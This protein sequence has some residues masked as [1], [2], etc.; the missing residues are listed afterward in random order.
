MPARRSAPILMA[1]ILVPLAS[2]AQPVGQSGMYSDVT[3]QGSILEPSPI[4]VADDAQLT[5]MI[6]APDGARVEVFARGLTNPRMLAVSDAGI[7][8]ATRRSVGDVVMLRDEDG[9]GQAEA[10]VTVAS[11][12]GMHGIAFDGDRV[13]LATVNDVYV[14]DVAADGT[15]GPLT[16]IITDL[17]DAGQHPNR[18][19]AVGP[20][21]KLYISAGSTCNACP[22]PNPENATMLRAEPDGS[23]RTIFASGLRNTI[24]FDWEP[25]SGQLWGID[26]GIDWLGDEAQIEELNHIR[27]GKN[28]GWPFIFGMGE[29]NP[30]DNPPPGTSLETWAAMSEEPKLGYTPHAAPM[31]MAFYDGAMFPEW[32]GDALVAMRGS[33]NRRPPSGYEVV[34]INYERGQPVSVEPVLSGFLVQQ[35][36][37]W[38]Y[39]GRPTGVAV[40]ADGAIFVA[41]DSQ[42]IIYRVSSDTP[43][44]GGPG[45]PAPNALMDPAPQP[46]AIDAVEAEGTLVVTSAFKANEGVAEA[47]TRNGDNASPPLQW[48]GAPE[49]TQSYVIIAD[50]P[51]A[52]SRKPTTHWIAYD[53]PAT[54]TALREGMPTEASLPDPAGMK[55]GTNSTGSTGYTGPNPPATDGPHNYHFQIFALDVPTLG[56][57]PAAD[58]AAVLDALRNHVLAKGEIVGTYDK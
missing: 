28:Y 57:D 14:A 8:Y 20:D 53:I 41:D 32:K 4:D 48:S 29:A 6:T 19:L 42:G 23:S 30:Q 12:A 24:G 45:A 51:D 21:G 27:Q 35:N 17:P 36:D 47:F 13:F 50:D 5:G 37:A 25:A 3:V 2:F 49:G 58:R 9:D 22:E 54:V 16:R 55:Q 39:L 56:L 1:G 38:G 10:P 34:R 26:H 7:L 40:G 31:Q 18:T 44:A 33:W 43:A 15:F 11:R 52:A 46:V